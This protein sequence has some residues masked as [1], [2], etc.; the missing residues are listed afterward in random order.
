MELRHLRYFVTVAELLNFTKAAKK[1]RVAQ[2]AL[3]RQIR[4]LEEELGVPLFE[5]SSRFVRLT[6]AGVSFVSEARAVLQ[7]AE[8]AAQSARAFATGERGQLHLGYAPSLTVELLPQA[9]Q[10]FLK[11]CPGIGV[12]LHDISNQEMFES[13]REGRLDVALTTPA[14][15][16]QMR[17]IAFQNLRTYPICVAVSKTH[18]LTRS[19][20]VSRAQLKAERLIV[21]GHAE[22]PEYHDLLARVFAPPGDVP[23]IAQEHDSAT[24]LMAA[25]EAGHGVSVTPSILSALAGP[26]LVL[27]ELHPSPTPLVVG[28]AYSRRHLSSTARRFVNVVSTS[29]AESAAPA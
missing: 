29:C 1:L 25:V 9:L 19:K 24:S 12:I 4:D 2:P 14:S 23:E 15:R 10:A 13:L 8:E 17:G 7:R 27:R 22:Y 21:Y 18:R 5:R 11:A 28:I 3:S 20:R 6:D 16:K 26:R